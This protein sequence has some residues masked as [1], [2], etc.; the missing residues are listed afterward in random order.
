MPVTATELSGSDL[1]QLVLT[2]VWDHASDD[3]KHLVDTA[4]HTFARTNS[5]FTS[6]HIW[7]YLES[8]G[9]TTHENRAMGAAFQRAA[10]KGLITKTNRT[11]PAQRKSRHSGDVRIWTSNVYATAQ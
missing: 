11:V 2:E 4:I 7:A 6:E 5:E 1:K 8:I 3:W 9:A 10:K